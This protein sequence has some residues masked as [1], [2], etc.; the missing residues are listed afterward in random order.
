V[1]ADTNISTCV[2]TSQKKTET[3]KNEKSWMK[4]ECSMKNGQ[5]NTFL[6]RQIIWHCAQFARKSVFKDYS[7]KRQ[8]VQN[9]AAK[10]DEY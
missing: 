10:F 2:M 3:P 8:Y 6:S 4:E 1:I 7:L 5:M 9:H